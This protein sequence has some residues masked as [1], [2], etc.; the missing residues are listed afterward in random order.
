L[1]LVPK[2]TWHVV[3]RNSV[4]QLRAE[5]I[6]RVHGGESVGGLLDS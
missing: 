5:A 3:A 4:F 1:V 6:R 2:S